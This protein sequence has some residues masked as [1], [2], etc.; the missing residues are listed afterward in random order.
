MANVRRSRS[1]YLW[2][3]WYFWY[4]SLSAMAA[5][6]SARAPTL[7]AVHKSDAKRT[8]STIVP[9]GPIPDDA[10]A[11]VSA[12]RHRGHEENTEGEQR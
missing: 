5:K 9:G 8:N 7:C 6:P 1:S 10:R 2:G 4:G 12:E 3:R 11:L